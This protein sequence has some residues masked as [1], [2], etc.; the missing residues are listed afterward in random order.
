MLSQIYQNTWFEKKFPELTKEIEHELP[1]IKLGN[2][3]INRCEEYIKRIFPYQPGVSKAKIE[4]F[5][6]NYFN[7]NETYYPRII[8]E[9]IKISFNDSSYDSD[10]K[11]IRNN[12]AKVP[13]H[14]SAESFKRAL[15]DELNNLISFESDLI[16]NKIF[17]KIFIESF[18]DETTPF[19][20]NLLTTKIKKKM[21]KE[22][23]KITREQIKDALNV[24]LH[25]KIFEQRPGYGNVNAW[26]AGTLF[27]T[28]LGM[29]YDRTINEDA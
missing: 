15:Q 2:L 11:K 27:K 9:F 21:S 26:R 19:K 12:W 16:K 24:M 23:K 22:A 25:L 6:K 3:S 10:T 5:F 14:K 8:M 18:K 29:K 1:S 20:S 28:A 17:V 4:N 7:D 13:Y